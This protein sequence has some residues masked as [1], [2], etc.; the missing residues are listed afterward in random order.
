MKYLIIPFVIIYG[1]ITGIIFLLYSIINIKNF[2][3]LDFQEYVNEY[4]CYAD[5]VL[6]YMDT[7]Y[8][9]LFTFIISYFI[10]G[11]IA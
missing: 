7:F 4:M 10:Y 11:Y 6:K 9:L 8:F 3:K 1:S 5:R 2:R